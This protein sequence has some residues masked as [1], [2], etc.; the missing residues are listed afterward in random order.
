MFKD[1]QLPFGSLDEDLL[2]VVAFD[3]SGDRLTTRDEAD[4]DLLVFEFW[5]ELWAMSL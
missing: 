4:N 2:W 3:G 5:D 1:Q